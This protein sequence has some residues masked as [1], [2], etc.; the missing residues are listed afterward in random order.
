MLNSTEVT[1]LNAFGLAKYLVIDVLLPKF[2][3]EI[4]FLEYPHAVD[5]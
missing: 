2:N 3:E 4:C 1:R 5:K